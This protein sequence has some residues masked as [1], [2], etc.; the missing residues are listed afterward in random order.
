MQY[1]QEDLESLDPALIEAILQMHQQGPQRNAIARQFR[2]AD[3][4]RGQ[5]QDQLAG[6]TLGRADAKGSMYLA[7][8][9]AN[10]AANLYGNYK[11]SKM[12]A[13]AESREQAMGQQTTDALRRYFEALGSGRRK[14]PQV[15]NG[16]DYGSY[17]I[18]Y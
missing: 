16:M 17:G 9:I 2:A 18:D 1:S 11:A 7:P 4:T 5:A 10:V 15:S 6:R 14:T 13:E 12:D 3:A 8:N